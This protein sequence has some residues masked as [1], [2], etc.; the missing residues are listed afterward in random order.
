MQL[1]FF[2][3]P[4]HPPGSNLT[5]TLAGDIEQIV[6]AD[7]LGYSE[8]WVGEH[9]A[10]PWENISAPDLVIANALALTENIKLGTGVSCLA[11]HNPFVL[12]HRIANLDHLA[13]GRFIWGIGPGSF[14][15]DIL[16]FELDAAGGEHR[17]TARD[18]L[19]QILSIWNDPTPGP[20][21]HPRWH[22]TIPEPNET[23][24]IG[25]HVKPYQQ[26]HPPIAVAG[27]SPN[28]ETLE[29]AGERGWI[30]MSINL[31]PPRY[32]Q[33][34][35]ESV[36]KGALRANRTPDRSL[37]R[38]ARDVYVADTAEQARKEAIE[39]TLGRDF[40]DFF[41][42]LLGNM[43]R[44]DLMKADPEMPD[45]ELTLEYMADNLW[46][47]GGPE[48]VAQQLRELYE[49]VGGFGVLLNMGHEWQPRERWIK[50]M[51]LLVEEVM[52]M[53]SDLD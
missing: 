16:S 51:T 25:V 53:L 52:P 33:S 29:I 2:T 48:E 20:V 46:V 50:S 26:P 38:V 18:A 4:L 7:R 8:A 49:E 37:W 35:W 40:Q 28:S 13:Q 11:Y 44:L 43:D 17:A 41:L 1:G 19:D 22:Y 24:G 9:Y 42:S 10:A 30:P 34:H 39:G 31:I 6:T 47:V 14:I 36:E 45:S 27:L 32:L 12:A 21:A 3:M 15:G 23:L 5:E